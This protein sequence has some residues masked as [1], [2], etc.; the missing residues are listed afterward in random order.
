M[1]T[2]GPLLLT[3]A[4]RPYKDVPNF[5]WFRNLLNNFL[6]SLKRKHHIAS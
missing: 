5:L 6:Q 1:H 4:L 2:R 3:L